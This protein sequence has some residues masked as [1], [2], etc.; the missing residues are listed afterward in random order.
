M[1]DIALP[2]GLENIAA[3]EALYDKYSPALYG[4]I[5]KRVIDSSAAAIVLEKSFLRI[6]K[7]RKS[8]DPSKSTVFS[9]MH[10]IT[11]QQCTKS[12]LQKKN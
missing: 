1:S 10:T 4:L 7:E 2:T 5:L 12:L 3:F 9:W 6:W 8:Y 11:L